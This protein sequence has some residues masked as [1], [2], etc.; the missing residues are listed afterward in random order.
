MTRLPNL[1]ILFSL[2]YYNFTTKFTYFTRIK[3]RLY[4]NLLFPTVYLN[5]IFFFKR[6]RVRTLFSKLSNNFTQIFI[7]SFFIRI[8]IY[9]FLTMTYNHTIIICERKQ[10]RIFMSK[11]L[12]YRNNRTPSSC[13]YTNMYTMV[14]QVFKCCRN[15]LLQTIFPSIFSAAYRTIIIKNDSIK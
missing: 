10:V 15:L 12:K 1:N 9:I 7:K 13:S 11:F 8:P 3:V 6:D 5:H 2:F 4:C 14:Q